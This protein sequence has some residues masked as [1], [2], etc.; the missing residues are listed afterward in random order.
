LIAAHINYR[1]RGEDS[2]NDELFVKE[3]C[4]NEN[5][6]LYILQASIQDDESV[7][8]KAREIRLNYFK[9][10]KKH[11]KMD[12][13][14][15][16]HHKHDQSET[17]LHRL[18]RGAGFTGLSGISPIKDELIHPLLSISKEELL[19]YL[20]QKNMS[21]R[22]DKTNLES[23]Y[24]RNKIRNDL[25]PLITKEYNPN[26]EQK[27]IEYSSLFYLT[28]TYFKQHIKKDFKKAVLNRTDSDIVFDVEYLK[29]IN[30]ILN[31]Y[32]F[33]EAWTLL[34]ETDK[35]FY[36]VHFYDIMSIVETNDGYKEVVL[37]EN[38]LVMKDY[39]SL[40]F[41]KQDKFKS[42]P[43][44]TSKEIA[45]IQNVFTFN[46]QRYTMKKLKLCPENGLGNGIDDIILDLDKI[47]FPII[48][49][50]RQ[51]GDKFIPFGMDGFKKIKNF[52]IDEKIP[53]L[54]RDFI[55]LFTDTEKILWVSGYR[56]DQRVA[57]STETRNFLHIKIDRGGKRQA[58]RLEA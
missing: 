27:L 13:I 38:V 20:K 58:M 40:I 11:Y 29:S 9:K 33:K 36:S 48:I 46:D 4:Y 30:P 43:K 31:F 25:L 41:R 34:T 7:Q 50:Y 16:G 26:F 12:Y 42:Q 55:V 21:Y 39:Q 18:I 37:P 32:L 2:D 53:L 3:F 28:D 44:E 5:I 1:L 19:E 24:T 45:K 15:L 6:P 10:L 22:T 17:V 47:I 52:F 8:K 56:I 35:D 51:P 23:H 49:R 54:E 57:V 14:A